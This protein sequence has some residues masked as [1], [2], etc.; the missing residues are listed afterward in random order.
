M[1][2]AVEWLGGTTLPG[3]ANEHLEAVTKLDERVEQ[4]VDAVTELFEHFLSWMLGILVDAVN[5]RLKEA[6]SDRQLCPDLSLFMRYGVDKPVG[7]TLA[8][9]GVRSRQLLHA[10]ANAAEEAGRVATV[11]DWLS[12]MSIADWRER[13][14]AS[15]VDILDLLDFTRAK[16]GAL[17]PDLLE[18]GRAALEIDLDAQPRD[19]AVVARVGP[20]ASDPRPN[21][22]VSLV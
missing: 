3:L 20:L 12:E 15:T 7:I 6:T 11:E 22:S 1:T 14:R 13:F 4:M 10:I 16:S 9:G 17:L 21:D 5:R 18:T 19:G 2:L 8:T